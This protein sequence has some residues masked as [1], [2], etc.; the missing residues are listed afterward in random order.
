MATAVTTLLDPAC[1]YT[2]SYTLEMNDSSSL[3]S[4]VTFTDSVPSI[5][6]NSVDLNDIGNHYLTLT[7]TDSDRG[8]ISAHGITITVIQPSDCVESISFADSSKTYYYTI[9]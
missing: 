3:V 6:I 9:G 8:L 2:I 1:S 4:F 7:A 5:T